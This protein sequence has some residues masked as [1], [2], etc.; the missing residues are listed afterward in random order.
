MLCSSCVFGKLQES[1]REKSHFKINIAKVLCHLQEGEK[2]EG[3]LPSPGGVL[4]FGEKMDQ[5]TIFWSSY[6]FWVL[7]LVHR[8]MFLGYLVLFFSRDLELLARSSISELEG[9]LRTL[10]IY[11]KIR[12]ILRNLAFRQICD[13]TESAVKNCFA[14]LEN[15]WA[16]MFDFTCMLVNSNCWSPLDAIQKFFFNL[17]LSSEFFVTLLDVKHML[18]K[19]IIDMDYC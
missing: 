19:M 5:A 11:H 15:V 9:P 14:K 10:I 13:D 18:I 6:L 4:I 12:E 3:P 17:K 7:I 8:K 2:G 16:Y 1:S